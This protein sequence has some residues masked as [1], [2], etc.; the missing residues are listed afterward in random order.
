MELKQHNQSLSYQVLGNCEVEYLPMVGDVLE[1]NLKEIVNAVQLSEEEYQK[2]C[3]GTYVCADFLPCRVEGGVITEVALAV[4]GDLKSV[5]P[6]TAWY[7]GGRNKLISQPF[8]GLNDPLE[9]II[10]SK[11]D[12]FE[13]LISLEGSYKTGY[14]EVV[15]REAGQLRDKVQILP[16]GVALTRFFDPHQIGLSKYLRQPALSL[17]NYGRLLSRAASDIRIRHYPYKEHLSPEDYLPFTEHSIGAVRSTIQ[18]VVALLLPAEVYDTWIENKTKNP[19]EGILKVVSV[20]RGVWEQN[21]VIE[22]EGFQ[23]LA[24]ICDTIDAVFSWKQ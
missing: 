14:I 1:L 15:K 2:L 21:R 6:Y 20:P 4:R 9:S 7:F 19:G 8:A 17:T 12:E 16:L 3:R 13:K 18:P 24:F 11:P 22:T 5:I 10:S 23:P